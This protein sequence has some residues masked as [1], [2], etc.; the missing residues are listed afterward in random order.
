MSIAD[1][2]G[3]CKLLILV[4]ITIF[5]FSFYG[6]GEKE[7]KSEKAQITVSFW[8]SPKEIKII[9]DVVGEWDKNHLEIEVLLDHTPYS[10]YISKILTRIAGGTAPDIIACEVNLFPN[11]WGK[12]VFLNLNPY[13]KKDKSFSKDAFFKDVLKRFTIDGKVYGIPRDT[14]PFACIYYNKHLFDKA[15]IEYPNDDWNWIDLLTKARKLTV[16]DKDGKIKQYGFYTWAWQNFVYSKGGSIVDNVGNPTEFTLDESKA[17]EGLQFYV[18]LIKKYKVSPSPMNLVNM[19]M[20][21]EMMFKT[22]RLAML[23]SGIWETPALRD[24]K[25]FKWD[26]AMF[27]K[28]PSGIRAFGTGGTGYAILQ[29]TKYPDMAWEIVK[30][31][32]STETQRRLAKT[33]LAQPARVKVAEGPAFAKNPKPPKNKDM[34]NEAVKYVV[35]EPFHSRW[36]EIKSLYITQKLDLVYMGKLG[37]EEAMDQLNPKINK[38]LESEK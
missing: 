13:I 35:Y 30:T 5:I 14:A 33:G 25:D 22:E 3:Y 15:G 7:K 16:R 17:V 31:L 12:D 2:N 10:G 28:G 19:G 36:R 11:F 23:G 26:V 1:R 6:C 34:L 29:S 18:D 4:I 8:G 9:E 20:G 32:T 21:V 37:V 24:I 27:P 38:I